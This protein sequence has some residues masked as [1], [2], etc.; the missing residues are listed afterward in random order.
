M[1][2]K[3]MYDAAKT[4]VSVV[5]CAA[6]VGW[7]TIS[8]GS[9]IVEAVKY[10][11]EPT[12]LISRMYDPIYEDYI[13]DNLVCESPARCEPNGRPSLQYFALLGEHEVRE[14][15]LDPAQHHAFVEDGQ[16]LDW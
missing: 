12:Y 15:R 6:F 16:N 9:D 7:C 13:P 2:M 3:K 8:A 5:F 10:R 4:V 14:W 1:N 11:N